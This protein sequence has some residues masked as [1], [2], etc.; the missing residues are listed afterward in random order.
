MGQHFSLLHRT[1]KAYHRCIICLSDTQLGKFSSEVLHLSLRANSSTKRGIKELQEVSRNL[2]YNSHF[3]LTIKNPNAYPLDLLLSS[4]EVS[5]PYLLILQLLHKKTQLIPIYSKMHHLLF[6]HIR[7]HGD[8]GRTGQVYG[9]VQIYAH[10]PA[11]P[12]HWS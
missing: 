1:S 11:I 4:R 10:L 12:S 6:S 9:C 2:S 3:L 8:G 7:L 5:L